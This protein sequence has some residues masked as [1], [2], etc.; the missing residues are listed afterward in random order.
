L[1]KILALLKKLGNKTQKT[2]GI[3]HIR[4]ADMQLQLQLMDGYF[5]IYAEFDKNWYTI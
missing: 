2:S 5:I 3:M 1:D 4:E